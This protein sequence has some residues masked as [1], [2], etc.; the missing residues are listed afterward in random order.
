MEFSQALQQAQSPSSQARQQLLQHLILAQRPGR[1]KAAPERT[2]CALKDAL[3]VHVRRPP[4][5]AVEFVAVALQRQAGVV[6]AFDDEVDIKRSGLDLRDDAVAALEQRGVDRALE[7]RLALA[8]QAFG[9]IDRAIER[10][11]KVPR[12]S[13][14]ANR[15][16]TGP[17][18]APSAPGTSGLAPGW[19]RR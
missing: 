3:A 13:R 7:A 15:P 18:Y 8:D 4:V 17:S 1:G 12:A 5:Q 10:L 6:G 16:A 2:A 11:G 14:R 19:Q 9:L